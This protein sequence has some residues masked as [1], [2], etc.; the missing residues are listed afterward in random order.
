M[1]EPQIF[2]AKRWHNVVPLKIDRITPNGDIYVHHCEECAQEE[3]YTPIEFDARYWYR[4]LYAIGFN[5]EI[6]TKTLEDLITDVELFEPD[7]LDREDFLERLQKVL[8]C[9]EDIEAEINNEEEDD[10]ED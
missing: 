8:S 1:K 6:A 3:E 4:N 9:I 10:E 7:K 5:L 2:C